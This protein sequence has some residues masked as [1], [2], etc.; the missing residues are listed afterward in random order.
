MGTV[1]DHTRCLRKKIETQS[2][3]RSRVAGTQFRGRVTPH[4]YRPANIGGA[5]LPPRINSLQ[6]HFAHFKLQRGRGGEVVGVNCMT[7]MP[8]SAER[9]YRGSHCCIYASKSTTCSG[10][11]SSGTK[12]CFNVTEQSAIG[13]HDTDNK[14]VFLRCCLRFVSLGRK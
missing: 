12:Y 4:T 1:R 2:L 5:W 6:C 11:S 10:Q 9:T 3:H 8:C 13:S 14:T 7:Q